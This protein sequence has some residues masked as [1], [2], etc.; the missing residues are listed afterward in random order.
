MVGVIGFKD[1]YSAWE[2]QIIS[3]IPDYKAED[4]SDFKVDAQQSQY[5]E[6]APKV[7][8]LQMNRLEYKD[9]EQ[10]K[11]RHKVDIEKKIMLDR[12]MLLNKEKHTKIRSTV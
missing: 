6:V 2:H 10:I 4:D 7:I 5:L 12:F 1:L 8:C 3:T 11:H 9:C